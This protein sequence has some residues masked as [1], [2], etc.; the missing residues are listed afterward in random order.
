M[1]NQLKMNLWILVIEFINL[2]ESFVM[3]YLFVFFL[4]SLSSIVIS[5]NRYHVDKTTLFSLNDSVVYLKHDMKPINGVL[6]NSCGDIG[7]YL[8]GKR[9]GLY[10][11]WWSNC[12]LRDERNYK[13]GKND[14]FERGWYE[15]GQL[16]YEFFYKELNFDG[17]N[18]WWYKN[19]QLEAER[20]YKN[21]ILNGIHRWWY[22]NGQLESER[23]YKDG[24]F[25]SE[26]CFDE[27]GNKIICD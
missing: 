6:Y 5:Q 10:R 11:M 18:R 1:F 12:Q 15:D 26:K 25:I 13:D 8:N 24:M 17:L 9:D 16:K 7:K 22:K 20:S 21:G 2:V 19:G 4:V 3:R 14:G 27:N 23:N